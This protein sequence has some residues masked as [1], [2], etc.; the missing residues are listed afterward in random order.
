MSAISHIAA[1]RRGRSGNSGRG[2]TLVELLAVI[3]IVAVLAAITW[4]MLGGVMR[5]VRDSR[6]ASNLR[7]IHVGM[8]T[9][10]SEWRHWPSLNRETPA[11]PAQYGSHPWY[12]SMLQLGYVPV[13][14]ET[15]DGFSCLV[16]DAF[17]CPSNETNTGARYQWTSAPFPWMP[18]YAISAYWGAHSGNPAV[19]TPDTDWVRTLGGIANPGAIILVDSS[20]GTSLYPSQHASWSAPGCMIARDVHSK[21]ANALLASGAVISVSPQSHPDIQDRKYWDPKYIAQ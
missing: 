10:A 1:S 3:A 8:A 9:Y 5:H 17:L 20:S 14:K 12:Y 11:N 18:N 21:G 6:C 7:T 13:K 19:V 15:R 16:S 2:F 4:A